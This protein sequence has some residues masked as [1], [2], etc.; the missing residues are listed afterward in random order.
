M[1]YRVIT[2]DETRTELDIVEMLSEELRLQRADGPDD[3]PVIIEEQVPRSDKV[4]VTV[5][6]DRWG[7]ISNDERSRTILEAY[8][9][10][11]G[12]QGLL[13]VSVALGLTR[14]EAMRLGIQF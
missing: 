4:Y 13:S 8:R 6:W 1:P 12:T 2:S 5:I 14:A 11:R 7:Q 10:E 9:R 3:A